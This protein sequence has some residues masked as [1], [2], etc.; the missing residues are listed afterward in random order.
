[1]LSPRIILR[2]DWLATNQIVLQYS[3]WFDGKLTTV[4][5]G[6][7]PVEDSSIVPDSNML[8][9]SANMWW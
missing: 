7:P 6:Y 9:L 4:R 8:S 3:H 5:T 1:V 2:T